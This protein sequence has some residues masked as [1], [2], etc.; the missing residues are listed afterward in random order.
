MSVLARDVAQKTAR[1][2]PSIQ[3]EEFKNGCSDSGQN[4]DD[5][6]STSDASGTL[7]IIFLARKDYSTRCV[8]EE[9]FMSGLAPDVAQKTARAHPSIQSEEF[10]NGCS[11]SAQNSDDDAST[12]DASGTLPIIF[13]ARKDYSN[14][15]ACSSPIHTP[16]IQ[17][18]SDTEEP[19]LLQAG[20]FVC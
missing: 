7:P 4:S 10:K 2:H 14:G 15:Y 6:A 12:S 19:F 17:R 1:A 20:T 5:D 11:D 8:P 3:S 18:Y 16:M 13:L 9:P